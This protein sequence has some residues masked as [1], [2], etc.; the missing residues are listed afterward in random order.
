MTAARVRTCPN[1]CK[2][3]FYKVEGCNKMTCPTC[4]S[5]ICYVCR[6][7]IPKS[8]GY[9]HFCQTPHCRHRSCNMCPL[10]TNAEEDDRRAAKEAGLKTLKQI[11]AEEKRN[12]G[13][14]GKKGDSTKRINVEGIVH[15]PSSSGAKR[16]ASRSDPNEMRIPMGMIRHHQNAGAISCGGRWKQKDKP[17]PGMPPSMFHR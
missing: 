1:G 12:G 11:K 7:I 5:S 17:S 10:Y 9:K 8:V 16:N 2:Q 14:D 4:K 3:P 13:G 6:K 15:S